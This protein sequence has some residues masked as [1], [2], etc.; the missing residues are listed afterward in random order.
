MFQEILIPTLELT[1]LP[2]AMSVAKTQLLGRW[3]EKWPG[4]EV[5]RSA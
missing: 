2:Q 5:R 3:H 1:A 4:A